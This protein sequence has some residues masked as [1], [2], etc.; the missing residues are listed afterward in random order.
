[1]RTCPYCGQEALSAR[2][3]SFLG[4]ARTVACDCCGRRI[5]VSWAGLLAVVPLFAGMLG[6]VHFGGSWWGIVSAALGA[7]GMFAFHEWLVPL[8]GR[9]G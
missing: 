8:V 3:K 5:S 4:P 7:V 1:M 6:M 9:D 2:R